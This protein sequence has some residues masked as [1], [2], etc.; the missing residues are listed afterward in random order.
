MSSLH[1][2]G[3]LEL[4]E[5]MH[6]QRREWAVQRIGWAVMLL[7]V[8]L[9]VVG[10]FGTG[11]ISTGSTEAGDGAL[12]AGYQRF[13]R[14]DGRT[15]L[16]FTVA[17]NLANESNEIELWLPTSYLEAV[18]V[19]GISPQP[20]ESKGAGDRTIFVFSVDDPSSSIDVEFSLRPRDMGRLHGEAGV[21]DGPT[22]RFD[23]ISYP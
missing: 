17:G 13:I 1:R 23:Q 5:D 7:V 8:I 22:V 18:E 16:S 3:D 10:L 21:T 9:G 12:A 20:A 2:V 4:D 19:Q 15:S 11:P 14:H 6:V